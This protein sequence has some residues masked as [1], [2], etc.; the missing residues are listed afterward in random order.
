MAVMVCLQPM[1]LRLQTVRTDLGVSCNCF[2]K[3]SVETRDT[4]SDQNRLE[5][6]EHSDGLVLFFLLFF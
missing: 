2:I 6:S 3:Q 5:L 1:M 4:E